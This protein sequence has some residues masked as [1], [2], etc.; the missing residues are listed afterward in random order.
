MSSN[1]T[2]MLGWIRRPRRSRTAAL[3]DACGTAL[4]RADRRG[5]ALIL[6]LGALA[7]ISI[8]A[9]VYVTVGQ[10]DR[11]TSA[12]LATNRRVSEFPDIFADYIAGVI[13]D[14]RLAVY[15]RPE[16]GVEGQGGPVG[17]HIGGGGGGPGGTNQGIAKAQERLRR[18][19]TDFPYTD[20]SMRSA[21]SLSPPGGTSPPAALRKFNAPGTHYDPATGQGIWDPPGGDV[22]AQLQNLRFDR[23]V[24]S[25]P[26]LASTQPSYLGSPNMSLRLYSEARST[27]VEQQA[28]MFYLDRRDWAHITNISPDGFFVNL[29]NLRPEAGGYIAKPGYTGGA[30]WHVGDAN[31]PRMS[32]NLSLI[33]MSGDVNDPLRAMDVRNEGVW[34]PGAAGPVAWDVTLGAPENVPAVWSSNQRYMLIPMNQPFIFNNPTG[35]SNPS[36][37]PGPAD[38]SSPYYPAYQYADAD[39]DGLADSRWFELT[40]SSD[41]A[42]LS[43]WIYRNLAAVDGYRLFCAVRVVDLSSLVNINTSTDGLIPP[44]NVAWLGETPSDIDG[45]RILSMSDSARDS[46]DWKAPNKGWGLTSIK[47]DGRPAWAGAQETDPYSDYSDYQINLALGD[48]PTALNASG[49][50]SGWL[51][52]DASKLAILTEGTL[53]EQAYGGGNQSLLQEGSSFYNISTGEQPGTGDDKAALRRLA[54][55]D[56]VGS[57]DPTSP[58]AS[59]VEDLGAGW[60]GMSDLA[61]LLTFWGINDDQVFTRLEQTLGNRYDDGAGT[62]LA[63]SA[64]RLSP[65]YSGRPIELDRLRHDSLARDIDRNAPPKPTGQVDPDSMSLVGASVRRQITMFSGNTPLLSSWLDSGDVTT[66]LKDEVPDLTHEFLKGLGASGGTSNSDVFDLYLE[67]LAD[68]ARAKDTW[69]LAG[70]QIQLDEYSTMFYGYAGPEFAIRLAAHLSANLIDIYDDDDEPTAF[71]VLV[72]EDAGLKAHFEQLIDGTITNPSATAFPWGAGNLFNLNDFRGEKFSGP[73][74]MA[75]TEAYNVYGVEAYPVLTEVAAMV[76]LTDAS[77]NAPAPYQ[78]D[79]DASGGGRP[80]VPI[81]GP[82]PPEITINVDGWDGDPTGNAWGPNGAWDNNPDLAFVGFAVQLTNPFEHK[83]SLG[84]ETG[85]VGALGD[86]EYLYYIE[87]NGRYFKLG[88]YNETSGDYENVELEAG[89]SRTFYVIANPTLQ[90]IAT[91]WDALLHAYNSA[92]NTVDVTKVQEWL[93][94]QFSVDNSTS[95]GTSS[96]PARMK[97]FNPVSGQLSPGTGFDNILVAGAQSQ[98]LLN[99]PATNRT[100]RLWRHM[101][102]Q[103]ATGLNYLPQHDLLVDRLEQNGTLV[104]TTL[105]PV[106]TSIHDEHVKDTVAGSESTAGGNIA[107]PNDN[108]GWTYVFYGLLRRGD[109]GGTLSGHNGIVPA[110]MIDAGAATTIV[111]SVPFQNSLVPSGSEANPGRLKDSHFGDFSRRYSHKKFADFLDLRDPDRPVIATIAN[112][113]YEKATYISSHTEVGFFKT[114]TIKPVDGDTL[115][116]PAMAAG[117]VALYPELGPGERKAIKTGQSVQ[118]PGATSFTIDTPLVRATDLLLVPALG[119]FEKLDVAPPTDTTYFNDDQWITFGESLAYAMHMNAVGTGD[120]LLRHLVRTVNGNERKY[121]LDGLNLR[122]D[123]FVPFYNSNSDPDRLYEPDNASNPDVRVGSGVPMAIDLISRFRGLGPKDKAVALTTKVM[124]QIN[125][126]TATPE[127]LRALPMLSP[128]LELNSNGDAEWWGSNTAMGAFGSGLPDAVMDASMKKAP[129][130]AA[131]LVSYRDRLAGEYRVWSYDYVAKPGSFGMN[132]DPF[133]YRLL[134][135]SGALWND[136]DAAAIVLRNYTGNPVGNKYELGRTLITGIEGL[137]EQPG[138]TSTAEA[139][140]AIVNADALLTPTDIDDLRQNLPTYLGTDED[141]GGNPIN[142]GVKSSGSD[143]VTIETQLYNAGAANDDIPNDYEERLAILSGLLNTTTTRSDTYAVWF[144]VQGYRES[145]VKNLRADDPLVPSYAR[146]F[147]MVVDRSNVTAQG[148]KPRIVLFREV[149]L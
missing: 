36:G 125:L 100:V 41:T 82:P 63:A 26:W 128:S 94:S 66:L 119:W 14:D 86:S 85:G 140:A 129:D 92:A 1:R 118:Y 74:N 38:W 10:G 22:K 55:Y 70:N 98:G 117:A 121:A 19:N 71:G 51:A 134:D 13:A 122:V 97:K 106:P 64:L 6:V 131:Q 72:T 99:R 67:T 79:D 28:Q 5:S 145:D 105:D 87:F 139:A 56:R 103:G 138:F 69:K 39:G 80:I 20:Y 52:S 44:T 57:M 141:T 18:E 31:P 89:E 11:R 96:M 107:G 88:N 123:D 78:G 126:D 137:R 37:T 60:F 114:K 95:T 84:S 46:V 136:A 143:V 32:D 33:N 76:V 110:W 147:L 130:V 81:G 21:P 120:P 101:N 16:F 68:A 142:M 42:N 54:F 34:I 104:N 40:D 2:A 108:S 4:P 30:G 146:R 3:A 90:D 58:M 48:T 59:S 73:D 17:G 61:E 124:G 35:Y 9:A 15:V 91:K 93:D 144:V 111:D 7:L 29:W 127:V 135:P 115:Y 109:Q 62:N 149:P 113:P 148:Q 12:A 50:F 133:G 116:E 24:A 27:S 45:R 23:R 83:I 49:L 8:L 75:T 43:S 132:G 47:R 65:I 112:H 102:V 77:H 53:G 25:D